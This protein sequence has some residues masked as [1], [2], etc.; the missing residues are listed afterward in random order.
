MWRN[1]KKRAAEIAALPEG[2]VIAC[3]DTE[4]TGLDMDNSKIIQFSGVK[5]RYENGSFVPVKG[6]EIDMYINP[7]QVLDKKITEITGITQEM[8]DTAL[9]E[10]EHFDAISEFL[11]TADAWAAYNAPFD[12]RMI[13]LMCERLHRYMNEPMYFDILEWARDL[14]AADETKNYKL[15]KIFR[16]L[17]PGEEKQFHDSMEDVYAMVAIM[18]PLAELYAELPEE[19]PKRLVHLEG[20]SLYFD[21]YKNRWNPK[22]ATRIRLTLSEGQKGDVFYDI[23][24]H[25]WNAKSDS[26]AKR[27]FQSIDMSEVEEQFLIRYAYRYGMRTVDEVAQSWLDYREKL[28]KSK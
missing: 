3:F 24:H 23:Y 2:S 10:S 26:R 5:C 20:A 27:L 17:K 13:H 11:G 9:P 14:I 4:T 15:E 16:L 8:V 1:A 7:E 21:R 19:P 18:Q 12:V 25:Y 28:I 6:T 22:N